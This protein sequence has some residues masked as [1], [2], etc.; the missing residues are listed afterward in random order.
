[1]NSADLGRML[2]YIKRVARA[3][4]FIH[5]KVPLIDPHSAKLVVERRKAVKRCFVEASLDLWLSTTLYEID[6]NTARV[7]VGGELLEVSIDVMEDVAESNAVY[8][9]S[10]HGVEKVAAFSVFTNMPCKLRFVA[11]EAPPTIEIGGVHMH[12]I[13]GC[14][15]WRDALSKIRSLGRKLRGLVLDTC[16]G[17]GYTAIASLAMGA[18]AVVTIEID[19]TVITIAMLNPWSRGLAVANS[20][21]RALVLHGDATKVVPQLPD[22]VFDYVVH[23]PPRFELGGELYSLEMYRE[24]YRVLKPGGKLFHYTGEPGRSRGKSI[25]K[26]IRERLIRAGFVDAKW[27]EEAR[28]FVARRPRR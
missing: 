14:D 1:L 7:R 2:D 16:M 11:P 21:G 5:A 9:V 20:V 23:D 24:L 3:T 17:L 26:G 28:G 22:E 18:N 10:K 25:V 4:R 19:P 6:C 15:P 27:I 8:T 13:E 12:R